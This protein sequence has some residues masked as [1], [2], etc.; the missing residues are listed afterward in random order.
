MKAE[1]F[2][3]ST[4]PFNNTCRLGE[5]KKT[6]ETAEFYELRCDICCSRQP[7]MQIKPFYHMYLSII[8]GD[9]SIPMDNGNERVCVRHHK[10]GRIHNGIKKI[11]I[12]M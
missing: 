11:E 6:A 12:T 3:I 8:R 2:H 5:K 4:L 10:Y 9:I 1:P 7:F